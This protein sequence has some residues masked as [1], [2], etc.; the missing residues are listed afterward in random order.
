[1]LVIMQIGSTVD[2]NLCCVDFFFYIAYFP[3][4]IYGCRIVFFFLECLLL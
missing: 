3:I 1:M 4:K 2:I